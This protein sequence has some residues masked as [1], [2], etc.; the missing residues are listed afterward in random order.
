MIS[1]KIVSEV[2]IDDWIT[3]NDQQRR[4]IIGEY[5]KELGVYEI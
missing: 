5:E 4:G 2:W 1:Q 3:R